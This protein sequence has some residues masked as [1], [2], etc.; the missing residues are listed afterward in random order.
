MALNRLKEGFDL[1]KGVFVAMFILVMHMV[2]I[3][4]LGLVVLFFRGFITYM[5]WIFLA[6]SLAIAV[7]AY[8]FFRRL[9][10]EGKSLKDV[11]ESPAFRGRSV[12][13]AVLGGLAS[14]R[15][16]APS[17]G[18]ALESGTAK[19]PLQLEDPDVQRARELTEL[20][21]LLE[22]ELI[23]PEEFRRAKEKLLT[24]RG[25]DRFGDVAEN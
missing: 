17:A 6:G 12:E 19:A 13:V 3:A 15:V 7:S 8:L 1:S 4:G 2:L 14:I 16:G 9:K 18:P 23:T 10:T 5:I 21:R 25:V 22:K 11:I 20:G 24:A